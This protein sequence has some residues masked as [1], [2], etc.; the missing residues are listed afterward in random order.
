MA[1][2]WRGTLAYLSGRNMKN[3]RDLCEEAEAEQDPKRL[4]K[5]AAQI[6]RILADKQVRL[7]NYQTRAQTKR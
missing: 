3:W 2:G 4:L 7:E 5:L 1:A 6:A